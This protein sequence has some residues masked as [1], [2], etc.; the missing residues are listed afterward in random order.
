[1]NSATQITA[2][3]P[4]QAAATVD[5][6]VTTPGGTSATSSAD[7]YTYVPPPAPTVTAVAPTS[8][9]TTGGTSVVI[10][11]TNFTGATAVKFGT[12]AATTFTVNSATQIT[13]TAPAQAAAT[14]DV[15]VTTPGG[16]S[17]TSSADQYT[18][19]VTAATITAV[20]TLANKASAGT[21]TL[22]VSPQH[23]GD[24]LVMAVKV[25]STTITASSVAGG[26][27]GSWGRVQGP[28]TGYAAHDLEIWAGV[29]TATGSSTVTVTFSGSVASIQTGLSAQEFSASGSSPTWSLDTG[30]G[31]SNA[32][33]A[34]VTFPRLTPAGTGEAY[35][36]FAPVANSGA[37]GTTSGFTYAVTADGDVA[38]YDA[39]VSA[40]VQPTATQSPAGVS[41]GIAIL[42]AAS[43]APPPAPTVTAVSP[44]SGPTTGGTSVT[45]TGTGF[46]GAS[47]VKFGTV[48][49]TT[50]TVNSATQIT[51]GAPA[52]SLGTVDVTVTTPGGTSATSNADQFTYTTP[53]AP[54]VMSLS[55]AS[56]PTSGGTAVTVAGTNLTGATAVKFGTTAA[57][58]FTVNSA[59][60]VT[61]TAPAG[62]AG[63]VDV[64]VTTP[65]GTSATSS[66][67]RYTYSTAP[68]TIS[69][70]GTLAQK[71]GTATTALAVTPQHAGDL[72]VLTVK[73]GS[74]T[75]TA[76]SITGGG[77]AT[78]T[79][80]EGPY[81]GF[82]GNDLEMWTGVVTT[83][84]AATVTVSFSSPVTSIY[85]GLAAQEFSSSKGAATTW[86]LDTGAGISNASSTTVT[87]PKLTPAGSGELYVG[88]APVANTGAGGSTAGVTYATTA[89]AD[90]TAYDTNVSAALQPTATQSPAGVSGAVAVL[91]VAS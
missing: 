30:G 17:A 27:V 20:G 83:T 12:V 61:A 9:P 37:A 42:F 47:A 90:V 1:V 34:T 60:Q 80:A 16:T 86:S 48:A 45:V 14:V 33:S 87:F 74:G 72:V 19:V 13:A 23:V 85:T 66:A 18:Y 71:Q 25:D 40:A 49:A 5:V 89:D 82:T 32:S 6:T 28:Y 4:A 84:G 15:T 69:A 38:A 35:F 88:Y 79:R 36:G 10:T 81:T 64:T 31:I 41:G 21:T 24:L 50:F 53:P 3:A 56:G 52:G 46:T 76:S 57:T 91:V 51:A 68:P 58:T 39:N 62:S 11:G 26:G 77:V 63:T 8:G 2:T 78:W 55:P 75:V 29:V 73:V 44:A 70:V 7:Q 54:T 59:T 65:G 22:A 67:D 43:S